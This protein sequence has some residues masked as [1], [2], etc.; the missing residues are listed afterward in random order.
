[1]DY[2]ALETDQEAANWQGCFAAAEKAG[3]SQEEAKECQ[4][5]ALQCPKCPW[6]SKA[7]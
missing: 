7:P 1:M 4:E 5:G 6:G 2:S 3:Y